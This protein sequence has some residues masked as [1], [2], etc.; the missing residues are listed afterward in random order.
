MGPCDLA[1]PAPGPMFERM[2][3]V[4]RMIATAALAGLVATAGCG[5]ATV[6]Y[7]EGYYSTAPPPAVVVE[8]R[9]IAPYSDGVWLDG[10]WGWNSDR[11]AWRRGHWD[12]ARPGYQWEPHR[13]QRDGNGWRMQAGHWR[14][15][16]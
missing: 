8:E 13:W 14:E 7:E 4:R 12:H 5:G 6:A 2:G 9:G 11:Y 10:Y 3:T 16:R 1:A 15:V